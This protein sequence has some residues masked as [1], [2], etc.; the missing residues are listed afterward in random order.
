MKGVTWAGGVTV[1][2]KGVG[3]VG[4]LEV[5]LLVAVEVLV[6]LDIMKLAQVR[7]VALEVW[8]TMDRLPKKAPMPGFREA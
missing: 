7:R 8:K 5:V 6:A 3:G 1:G 4:V 2:V